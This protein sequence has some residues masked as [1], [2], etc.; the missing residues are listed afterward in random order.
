[1]RESLLD[2]CRVEAT[3]LRLLVADSGLIF[4][5][6]I[7][8]TV[9]GA[10]I[11]IGLV[12]VRRRRGQMARQVGLEVAAVQGEVRRGQDIEAVV[13]ISQTKGLEGIDPGLV[14]TESYAA[15]TDETD[16]NG[17]TYTTRGTKMAK[18]HESWLPIEE[19]LG[20]QSV[21]VTVPK[22]APFS[23]EG[24]ALSFEWEV[25]VRGRRHLAP[26]ALAKC[27]ITVLP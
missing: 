19:I 21:R 24:S 23:Y 6:A 1:V 3:V 2:R 20:T 22:D 8:V 25:L 15:E 16:M 4:F 14:C 12:L 13:S 26:D 11:V 10:W 18:A 9:V 5:I 7:A 17:N 27:P